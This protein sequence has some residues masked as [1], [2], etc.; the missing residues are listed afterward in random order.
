MSPSLRNPIAIGLV[1]ILLLLLAGSTFASV[2]ET[3][4][5]VIT[6]FGKPVRT[7]NA[8]RNGEEFGRTGA[9]LIAR[10]PFIEHIQWIDKRIL[11]LEMPR[12]QVLSSD[13][14]RLQVDAFARYRIVD[15]L[16]MFRSAHSEAQLGDQLKPILGSAIRNELGKRQF[17]VL[18]SAER[19]QMMGNIKA[20]LNTAAQQYGA[21]I[22]DVRIKRADL[23]EGTPLASAYQRM[24]SAREQE[25]TSI[26]AQGYKQAQII[27]AQ[28]DAEA[29]KTYAE[30]FGKDPDFYD[31][32]RAM[33]SY[34][35]TFTGEGQPP[36]QEQ[37]R[38]TV[39]L[40]PD[41]D[42]LREFRGR[43]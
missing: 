17:A 36:N 6:R 7:V 19:G 3:A 37:G 42:Y 1:A 39:I 27:R 18:L 20:A 30:A 23:P 2:P 9:G 16:R 4:Q 31:F 22:V 34:K 26:R 10:W 11:S 12:Q 21:E 35:T 32:Y 5:A 43:K 33:Q 24:A 15:P 8:Y 29:A 38:S 14:Y 25:A 41:N 13:Q 28:A 40:S